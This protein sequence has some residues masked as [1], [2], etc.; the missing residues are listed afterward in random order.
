MKRIEH[1]KNGRTPSKAQRVACMGRHAWHQ[2]SKQSVRL[3]ICCVALAYW[4]FSSI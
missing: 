1:D 3:A 4:K 2:D